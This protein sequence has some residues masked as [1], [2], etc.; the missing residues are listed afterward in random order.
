MSYLLFLYICIPEH[1]N[2]ILRLKKKKLILNKICKNI[3]NVVV[4]PF[5]SILK[6]YT[7]CCYTVR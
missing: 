7:A 2:N 6:E 1:V 4:I 3:I 5:L